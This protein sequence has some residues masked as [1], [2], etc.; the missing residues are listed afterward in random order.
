[1]GVVG[2]SGTLAEMIFGTL[3]LVGGYIVIGGISEMIR[4]PGRSRARRE[5]ERRMQAAVDE[6]NAEARAQG[7]SND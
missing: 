2:G 6:I 3:L 5:G 1:M 7:K 4:E